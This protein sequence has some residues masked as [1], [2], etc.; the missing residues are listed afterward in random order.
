MQVEETTKKGL[1]YRSSADQKRTFRLVALSLVQYSTVQYSGVSILNPVYGKL[2]VKS[3]FTQLRDSKT[4][5][6]AIARRKFE[7]ATSG[8]PL[9]IELY[10]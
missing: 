2:C 10:Q 7:L 5:Y 6:A 9:Q 4:G 3:D 8:L 1:L